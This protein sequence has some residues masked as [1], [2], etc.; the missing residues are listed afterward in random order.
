MPLNQE[1]VTNSPIHGWID[2]PES[3]P[4]KVDRWTRALLTVGNDKHQLWRGYNFTAIGS[5]LVS[6]GGK[7]AYFVNSNYSRPDFRYFFRVSNAAILRSFFYPVGWKYNASSPAFIINKNIAVQNDQSITSAM[8]ICTAPLTT[9]VTLDTA[10]FKIHMGSA[11]GPGGIYSSGG[12]ENNSFLADLNTTT[13]FE[14][15]AT[16]DDTAIY[17]EFSWTEF[18]PYD[19]PP[20]VVLP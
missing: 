2:G 11:S 17:M 18:I 9:G 4:I 1:K 16:T 5:T 8:S 15:T 13:M 19:T 20:L 14:I 3:R 7:L 12:Q 10:L 6:T